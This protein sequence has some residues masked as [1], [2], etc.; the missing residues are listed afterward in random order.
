MVSIVDHRALAQ[1]RLATQFREASNLINY[2]R[3]LLREADDLETVFQDLL[4]DRYLDTAEGVQLDILGEIIGL[5]RTEVLSTG[6]DFFGFFGA[7]SAGTFDS[8]SSEV[9]SAL[10][11]SISDEE[12]PQAIV[13]DTQYRRLLR[14]A[15]IKNNMTPTVNNVISAVM[16]G[17]DSTPVVIAE[18]K[19]DFTVTFDR[20]LT[21]D[22]KLYVI[23]SKLTPRPAGVSA[24]HADSNGI[25]TI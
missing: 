6:D 4:N 14:A 1:S 17:F 16:I 24:K 9:S 25:F 15:I 3:S 22:E 19:A 18:S 20:V 12:Y 21:D 5:S 10:F 11:L 23:T 7:I 8:T 2:I 13:T